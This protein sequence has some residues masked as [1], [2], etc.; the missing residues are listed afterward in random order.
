MFFIK[1]FDLL[2]LFFFSLSLIPEVVIISNLFESHFTLKLL[3]KVFLR[4]KTCNVVLYS[5]KHEEII[6]LLSSFL[7][8]SLISSGQYG[9]KMLSKA[10]GSEKQ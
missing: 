10:E 4:I 5:S 6:S 2:C 8:I 7:L 9:Q 1:V 3:I